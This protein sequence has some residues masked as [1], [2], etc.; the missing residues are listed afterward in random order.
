MPA[1]KWSARV[2][3]DNISCLVC[4]IRGLTS[5][6]GGSLMPDNFADSSIM[7]FRARISLMLNSIVI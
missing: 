4:D 1:S 2:S 6:G 3:S 7:L 5:G